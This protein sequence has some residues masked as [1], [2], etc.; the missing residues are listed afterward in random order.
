MSSSSSSAQG[1]LV[2]ILALAGGFFL[3]KGCSTDTDPGSHPRNNTY[4]TTLPPPVN[5]LSPS[6]AVADEEPPLKPNRPNRKV[7]R[8][9]GPPARIYIRGPRGGCYYI[10]SNGNKTY[11]D[12]SFCN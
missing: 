2:I 6:P 9:A 5:N 3:G 7:R 11:V 1:C 8:A 10:N 4:E 12:R